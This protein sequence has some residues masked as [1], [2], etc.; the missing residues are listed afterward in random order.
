[1]VLSETGYEAVGIKA[2]HVAT[3]GD[4]RFMLGVGSAANE[5]R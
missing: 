2:R 5:N 1:M 3:A 4:A